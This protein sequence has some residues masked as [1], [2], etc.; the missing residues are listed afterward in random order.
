MGQAS[1][2]P[3][4]ARIAPRRA[5]CPKGRPWRRPAPRSVAGRFPAARLA[6]VL[7]NCWATAPRSFAPQGPS[8]QTTDAILPIP[9][10]SDRRRTGSPMSWHERVL[11]G[12][13]TRP[14]KL[15]RLCRLFVLSRVAGFYGFR[16]SRQ[17]ELP[18]PHRRQ[19][20]PGRSHATSLAKGDAVRRPFFPARPITRSGGRPVGATPE[21]RPTAT[22]AVG[23]PPPRSARGSRIGT[24]KTLRATCAP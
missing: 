14:V 18:E 22:A 20:R 11:A 15:Y 23:S 16:R 7:G 9:H 21:G 3:P 19:G 5:D 12:P 24:G 13:A 2:G 17:D 4:P 8:R 1:G 10:P 6:S